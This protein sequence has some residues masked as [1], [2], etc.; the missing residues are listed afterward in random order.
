M[1]DTDAPSAPQQLRRIAI[2]NRGEPAMRFINAAREHALETGNALT[3]IALY[4]DTDRHSM[5][6]R[7]ADEA[8]HLGPATS[9]DAD[10][11]RRVTYLDLSRLEHALRS[12]RADAAWAGWGFVAEDPQFVELCD[13]LGVTFIGPT[14]EVMRLLGDKITSKQ[15][16]ESSDVTVAPWSGGPVE[17]V[18]EALHHAARIDFP[19]LVKATAGGGGRGIR[20]VD[21]PSELAEALE[22]ARS[23]A[24]LAF[25]DD[26]VFL[27]SLVPGAHHIEVQIVGDNDGTVWPVGLRDC[28]TQ[29]RNQKLLEE[30]PSPSLTAEQHREVLDAAA[31]LGRA[32][33]YR[34]AGTVEFLYQPE[35]QSLAF[36]E[37]NARLQV[38]HPITELTAG[39]DLVKLQLHIAAGGR[40]EGD[41]PQPNGWAIEARVNAED[42]EQGFTP[43]P[44]RIEI[45]RFPT[46]PGLRIDTGVEEGDSIP[47]EFDSMI[48]KVMAHGRT[49]TEATARLHR[50]LTDLEVVVRDGTTNA[51]L[52]RRILETEAWREAAIDVAWV[53]RL[54]ADGG[55][56]SDLG[57]IA[58]LAAAIDAH[59]TERAVEIAAF[60]A[61]AVRGRPEIEDRLGRRIELRH[62]GRTLQLDVRRLGPGDYRIT[63]DGHDITVHREQM[64]PARTV[65]TVA[66]HRHRI[67]SAVHGVTHFVEVDGEPHRIVHDEGGV[68]RSPAPAVVVLIDVS[69]GDHVE[70]GDRLAVIEAMKME[71]ALTADFAGTV[72][73]IDVRQNDQVD[74]GDRL[75]VIEP[76][77]GAGE[78][79]SAV[80][81]LTFDELAAEQSGDVDPCARWLH[82]VRQMLLGYDLDPREVRQLG[83]HA[84]DPCTDPLAPADQ[85]QR[86][87]E[88][89][90][91]FADVV[92]LFGHEAD[93]D[94]DPLLRHGTEGYMFDYLRRVDAQGADLPDSF[95]TRLERTLR[96]FGV[97]GLEPDPDLDTALARIVR[98][99]QRMI[100]QIPPVLQLLERRLTRAAPA[101]A[102]DDADARRVLL[103]DVAR[104][105]R[106]EFPAVHDLA[107]EVAYREIDEPF[108]TE[109]RWQV[110]EEASDH[111]DA[112]A[113]VTDPAARTPHIAA[114]VDCPQPLRGLLSARFAEGAPRV[115]AG[116]L[117][118]M[119]RRYYRIRELQTLDIDT[120]D[121]V[122]VLHAS[123]AHDD[124]PVRLVA[125]QVDVDELDLAAS[126]VSERLQANGAADTVLDVYLWSPSAVDDESLASIHQRLDEH[127]GAFELRRIAVAVTEP[128][129]SGAAGPMATPSR[130]RHITLRPDG[131]GRYAEQPLERDLHPMMAKRLELSRLDAFDVRRVSTR[132]GV[133][134]FHGT[135]KENRRDERL[136]AVAEVRDLAAVR[137]DDGTLLRLP[138]LERVVHDVTGAMRRFQAQRPAHKRLEWNRIL[139][140]LW[141]RL[142]LTSAE[143][144]RVV[145]RLAPAVDGL[146]LQKVQVLARVELPTGRSALRVLEMSNP[147]GGD[148]PNVSMHPPSDLAIRPLAPHEQNVVR[149]RQRGLTDPYDLL[150]TLAPRSEDARRGIPPGTWSEWDLVG[151]PDE[152]GNPTLVAVN[153]LVGENTANI[154]VAVVRNDS[155]KYDDGMHRVAI[156]GDPSRGMGNLA[157]A[158]CRRII[159]ALD[160]AEE[161]GV[162]AEWHAV[163]AGAKIAM[164]SGTENMDWISA[165]LRRII[166]FTQAGHHLN[167]VV[168]GISVGAQPY[169]NAEATMLMH[170]K[171]VL[172]MVPT[173]TM[174]LTGK[175]A[176]DYSGG[177]SAEDNLGIGGY[178]RVMGPNGQ[179]QYLAHDVPDAC[180]L[181][182][183]HYDF[184][185]SA[186]GERFPRDA[187]TTDV[188]D[189]DILAMPHG[190]EF[191]TLA[192]LFSEH[193]NPGRKKPFQMRKVMKAVVDQDHPTMERW[194]AMSDAEVPIVWNAYLGGHPVCLLG[195]EAQNMPRTGIAPTDG[196]TRWTSSTLFPRGSKKVARAINS[197]S[198]N[199]PLVVLASLSGFD[200]SPESMRTWQLEF[201]AEIGRAIVNFD[202][203]IVFCVVSRY[204]GGAFVVFSGALNDHMEVAALEGSH[205]SVIGGAPAAAVVFARDVNQRTDADPRIVEAR[206]RRYRTL[207]D[208]REQVRAEK[209]GEVAAE[210]D[211][212]HDVH[213]ALEVG[214][215][216]RIIAPRELRP[217]L[218][219]AVE[220]GMASTGA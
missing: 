114:L 97:V 146:G 9:V 176:L 122:T 142:E 38:E 116:V 147:S 161:L 195:F 56:A 134:L 64:G 217:Y 11:N 79:A 126:L 143:I 133:Y 213:R 212:I 148:D 123:Y 167:V 36:M 51:A 139:L 155:R 187:V 60:R 113:T 220:R 76:D 68:V 106:R 121:G 153:R 94:D 70:A 20:K 119:T 71:T 183:Q 65:L 67:V 110:L 188:V 42:P 180:R 169:W 95:V 19:L 30:S 84:D 145:A 189:R 199:R 193:T 191:P 162:P 163:S 3:T 54:A 34:S 156:V 117:E 27:E 4:T 49:R 35:D 125:T 62:R 80:P 66:G 151:P 43:A 25:G 127:L 149:L 17:S 72:R 85:R 37:V 10:G 91:I 82:A 154:V 208:I 2:V 48:A 175:D 52:L 40:L 75:V 61:S 215:I 144:A 81:G 13:S 184:T 207:S 159:A 86:E 90:Q 190:G 14:A 166:E 98:S 158:E 205:A 96:H 102:T 57:E 100:Q 31:R 173:S 77:T 120:V 201:G 33:G 107:R 50:A 88:V 69:L 140:Y 138:E 164:D 53:D 46:G 8:Y 5:F 131:E 177:V 21:D 172:I 132:D 194:F 171:G 130:T 22:S 1:N 137:D 206:E 219:D 39:L 160:L 141:P 103:D 32:A 6:V 26:R 74:T 63:V 23:E 203:P 47:P 101:L 218:I 58:V 170:T 105:T 111:L 129:D 55:I 15:I 92:S 93:P 118:V 83:S 157:E 182:L 216:D 210:F 165:V 198:A 89:L 135:A 185:W 128:S 104:T 204:H 124:N 152:D 7:E 87:D 29:R 178:E 112:L 192:E 45:L 115:R 109:R 211:G 214:S 150:S 186:P 41:P 196:P 136:F 108:L 18:D 28:S 179:A 197:A 174:V 73:S 24:R 200:G 202:G 78:Q 99:H 12:T 16:A 181:L 168:T 59:R 44:G 209:L